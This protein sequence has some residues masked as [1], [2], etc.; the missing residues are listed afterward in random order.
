MTSQIQDQVIE[1]YRLS[2]YQKHLWLLQQDG[3]AYCSVC[4]IMIDG[5][6]DVARLHS[7]ISEVVMRHE[8]LR[9]S[10][11]R[12]AGIKVPVQVI[13]DSGSFGW[14][15]ID[16]SEEDAETQ[17]AKLTKLYEQERVRG[18]DFEGGMVLHA[19]LSALS[20]DRHGLIIGLPSLCADA[21]TLRNLFIE[22][23]QCYGAQRDQSAE[24]PYQYADFSEW[25]NELV[26]SVEAEAERGRDFWRKQETGAP[27]S[28][29]LPFE[30]RPGTEAAAVH[31]A[32]PERVEVRIDAAVADSIRKLAAHSGDTPEAMLLACWQTLLWR[33]SGQAEV[34]VGY[35][36]DG[37]KYEELRGAAGLF[38]QAVPVRV[39]IEG[40]ARFIDFVARV[41][42]KV[43][44]AKEWEAY[45]DGSEAASGSDS[46]ALAIGGIGYQ[47]EQ[48]EAAPYEARGVRFHL[49]R[50]HS[51]IERFK[52][53]LNCVRVGE[54]LLAEIE[55][56]ER[57]YE[58]AS[59][60]QIAGY[61]QHL[62]SSAIAQPEAQ[63]SRLQFLTEHQRRQ[64][65]SEWNQTTA[66]YP[67]ER[68]IHQLFEAQV[69]RTPNAPAI[70]SADQQITYGEL[71]ERANQLAH[72]LRQLGVGPS[73][74]VGLLMDRSIQMMVGV[75]GILKAGAAYLPLNT[76]HP[77]ARLS[78]Q[79]SD[80][81]A[82]VL[83]TETKLAAELPK[84]EGHVLCLDRDRN[85]IESA[86]LS[87]PE[88]VAT[89][90]DFVY[91]IY[92]SG[93]TGVPKGV[94]VRHRNLVNYTHA[95]SQQLQPGATG[96]NQRAAANEEQTGGA[97]STAARQW[98]YASVTTISADL[99][100]TS[101]YPALT[102]G[103]CLHL[104]SYDAATD[105]T[106]FAH[107][108]EQHP[109]DVLKIVPSHL[110]ALLASSGGRRV[111]PQRYLV[112][113]GEA[114]SWELVRRVRESLG[115]SQTCRIINH[116][117]PT[118][119]TVGSLTYHLGEAND[120]QQQQSAEQ[121]A[122][123][124]IGKPIA[125]TQAYILDEQ[126]Q[127]VPTGVVGELYVGGEGVAA[128]Y[129]H[130]EEQTRERF[131][132]DPFSEHAEARMYKTGDLVRYLADG[133]IEFLG[134]RD[135]QVKI[136]GY[137][138]E[139]A[140]VEAVVREHEPVR[141]AVVVAREDQPGDKRLVAYLVAANEQAL[142]TDKLRAFLREKLP[143]YMVPQTFVLLKALPLTRNGKV[144]RRALP[145][146]EQE[147]AE[148]RR[149]FVP[150]RTPTEEVLAGIWAEVLGLEQV[151]V[152]DN[153]FALGGHS[154]LVT[155]V[156][157]RA[158]ATFE[159]ELPL[160]SIFESPTVAGLADSIEVA[161]QSVK[162]MQSLAILPVTRRENIPLSFAQQRLWFLDQLEPGNFLYNVPRAFRISGDL[163]VEAL[164][165]TFD[166]IVA[167]H[168]VLR[169]T[170]ATVD[171][172][173]VQVIAES[174]SVGLPIV[175]LS[176]LEENEREAE[177]R[178]RVLEEAQR[179]F[180]LQSG[181]LLRT[182]LLRLGEKEHVLLLTMHH[183]VSD[184]WSAGILFRELRALYEGFSTELSTDQPPPL[185]ELPIQY[186]DYA[187]WQREWLQ[188]EVL[189]KQLAYWREQ[190]G[191]VL[192]V[193]ELPTDRSRPA[194][195]TFRGTFRFVTFPNQIMDGLDALSQSEGATLFMTLLA[196]FQ[197]LL[198]R[199]SGQEDMIVG[200]TTAG[201]NRAE[202]EDLIGFFTNTLM[203]RTNLSGDPSFRELLG[204]V[205]EVTI[206]AYAHEDIPFEKLV[207]ELDPE[208]IL[209]RKLLSRVRFAL[210]NAQQPL[211][212]P[213]LTLSRFEYDSGMARYDLALFMEKSE[214]GLSA[215]WTYKTDLFDAATITRMSN[216][217]ETLLSSIVARPDA[218]LSALKAELVEADKQQQA[219]Q[220]G[221]R[222]ESKLKKLMSVAPKAVSVA[223]G[224]LVKTDYLHPG[225][226]SPL[227]IQPDTESINLIT[228]A[229]SN[230]EF[231]ETELLKHGALLF[232]GFR[233]GPDTE[234]EQFI[235]AI[236]GELLEYS[237]RSTPRTQVN[238][239]IYTS[240]EYPHDQSIPLHNEMS[241]S[242]SWP[243]KIWFSCVKS[244]E[245]GGETPIADSRKVYQRINPTIRERFADKGVMYV[246]N[247]GD[248]LDLS[249]QNVFQTENKSDVEEFCRKAG[250]EFEWTSNNRLRTR[251]L[252]QAVATHP[253]VGE[254]VWFNQAHLFHIS[255][256]E[257]DIRESLLSSFRAEDL[258]R[259]AY[260]GD[261]SQI[262][263]DVLDEIR[264]VYRQ[265]QVVFPWQEGDILMLDNMLM[266]HGRAPFVGSRKV[267]VGMAEPSK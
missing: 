204:R 84:Y 248:G 181:P 3:T 85:Q 244:A 122:T 9:T 37:R 140:E 252:C 125:N 146:P 135:D 158:R 160:R 60:E 123:V 61:Y 129:L 76:D 188:G 255:S 6:L 11:H 79:L 1:G 58:R 225:Q 72:H 117:G 137:R 258:P 41:G 156:I 118:E 133:Q 232:R 7:A 31:V 231:I 161:R 150:P 184:G 126:L 88:P 267:L 239:R 242:S 206:G 149:D 213:G 53:K 157:S 145:D 191:G 39:E 142:K 209:S 247:Y 170:F 40:R 138:V 169:T 243:M 207:E 116:Y 266:A 20:P 94:A 4:A 151:S 152:H 45:Y 226:S 38:A 190:L 29:T 44:E 51:R 16:L 134:R 22:I 65:I 107:Y 120:E 73:A 104:I 175:D 164:R 199:Y 143:E 128:G 27:T 174:L 15:Q 136:R 251:Q 245:Q 219:A 111:L 105:A 264:D 221:E 230:R 100:N 132:V 144:D 35:V 80:A 52:L 114:L 241:Y 220:Q 189:E 82:T 78:H 28:V 67:R 165:R 23:S 223:G 203:L 113:G 48:R 64:L 5:S 70:V 163:N 227:V 233:L 155:Q 77:A 210:D 89:P 249:W 211:H 238:G 183:I 18:I 54:S 43:S 193:T 127:V 218:Q 186:A 106:S 180:D 187:V 261:G 159:V 222:K 99:G 147:Q 260:Y 200:S 112:F 254:M 141:E 253:K 139:L 259:N 71:N 257:A 24:D 59:V 87:N 250:I 179:P 216:S 162:S 167:R 97:A 234:F 121:S 66:E 192:P 236:S 108:L 171:G 92:T 202:I 75:L 57:A 240:T 130:Q 262:E 185:P 208:R 212:F 115:G 98:Q 10:F 12:T 14:Q 246:R 265:E 201:R 8:I 68:C 2:S 124:P 46:Q 69:E 168:E 166:V 103:G 102:S 50:Q 217:F 109:V 34:S 25:R 263:D 228:W 154:L 101:I 235:A 177:A 17:E 229:G 26:E 110:S 74:V 47:Y 214:Q 176:Q 196:A 91:V 36:S 148:L 33:L 205:R 131:I 195:Q 19:T 256:L 173:P 172:N 81:A 96:E 119:T 13:H 237:Y 83:V 90:E 56:D 153:F 178:R 215:H 95:I 194:E 93:S 86:P 224:K 63:L 197:T 182:S 55:Y 32:A 30:A 49:E 62:L 198:S 42:E 21:Q